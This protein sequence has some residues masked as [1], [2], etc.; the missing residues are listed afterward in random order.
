MVTAD[1]QNFNA[2]QN[3]E[4]PLLS[5][6]VVKWSFVQFE[7]P[8]EVD[9]DGKPILNTAGDQYADPMVRN[10]SR[11]VLTITRNEVKDPSLITW[12]YRDTV[13]STPFAGADP[14][15]AK[16][17]DIQADQADDP[18][19]G[20]YWIVTYVIHFNPKKWT[21]KIISMG[22]NQIKDGNKI[23]ITIGGKNADTPQILDENGAY[24]APPITADNIYVQEYKV[25]D[26]TDFNDFNFGDLFS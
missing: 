18:V 8:I 2:E 26:E 19:Q 10:Q 5:K 9:R 7:E 6:P 4:N 13:N 22:L 21:Q 3:N 25:Y 23:P 12:R 1:Y 15:M 24:V 11:P 16:I 20:K 17:E 14:G